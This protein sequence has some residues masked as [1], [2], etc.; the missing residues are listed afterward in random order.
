[1]KKKR[2]RLTAY[3]P[4]DSLSGPEKVECSKCGRDS[5]LPP[6]LTIKNLSHRLTFNGWVPSTDSPGEWV[7]PECWDEIAPEDEYV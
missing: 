1:M 5:G 3:V 4:K 7:C 2:A 6:Y